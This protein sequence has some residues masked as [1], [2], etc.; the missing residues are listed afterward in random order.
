MEEG[1]KKSFQIGSSSS[2][3]T[4]FFKDRSA[5]ALQKISE[6]VYPSFPSPARACPF[7]ML[8]FDVYTP[9]AHRYSMIVADFDV[10]ESSDALRPSP[11]T[12]P[13]WLGCR[14]RALEPISH[15]HLPLLLYPHR[16]AG[17]GNLLSSALPPLEPFLA[18][19]LA[20]WHAPDLSQERTRTAAFCPLLPFVCFVR[21]FANR[22]CLPACPRPPMSPLPDVPAASLVCPHAVAFLPDL[23]LPA[24]KCRFR[25]LFAEHRAR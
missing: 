22:L 6:A 9:A 10:E 20:L 18:S 15:L 1:I 2:F 19:S 24:L 3:L 16:R 5:G 25:A 17:G 4:D 12:T 8:P 7:I 11:P 14:S 21:R 13:R 23:R